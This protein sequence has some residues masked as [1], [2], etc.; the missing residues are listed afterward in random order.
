MYSLVNYIIKFINKYSSVSNFYIEEQLEYD[1]SIFEFY[2]ALI[3]F[4]IL[5]IIFIRFLIKNYTLKKLLIFITTRFMFAMLFFLI[6]FL[7]SDFTICETPINRGLKSLINT[8]NKKYLCIAAITVTGCFI[9]YK[10]IPT[11]YEGIKSHNK[12]TIYLNK[13]ENFNLNQKIYLEYMNKKSSLKN[14]F[15]ENWDIICNNFKHSI[16]EFFKLNNKFAERIKYFENHTG[17]RK[18]NDQL[19]EYLLPMFKGKFNS[20]LFQIFSNYKE[21]LKIM[22]DFKTHEKVYNLNSELLNTNHL[23]FLEE[24]SKLFDFYENEVNNSLVEIERFSPLYK[25]NVLLE[26]L[27]KTKHLKTFIKLEELLESTNNSSLLLLTFVE[28]TLES[29]LEL[30]NMDHLFNLNVIPKPKRPKIVDYPLENL[31]GFRF[32]GINL[33]Y[34]FFYPILYC[35]NKIIGTT[36]PLSFIAFKKAITF[37]IGGSGIF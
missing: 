26:D 11:W 37:F 13:K 15:L 16:L 22:N 21:T 12:Y 14:S 10:Y 4:F 6:I 8:D 36:N 1:L 17:F 5:T 32:I 19:T 31:E 20:K 7:T 34:I 24:L 25:N 35:S 33:G 28:E 27:F 29:P 3:L 23:V 2:N 9:G 30:N 18:G